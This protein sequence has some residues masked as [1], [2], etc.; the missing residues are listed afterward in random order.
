M[1]APAS[2]KASTYRSG[3]SIIRCTSRVSW[4]ALRSE[5]TTGTPIEMLGTKWPSITSTWS[6][7]APPCSTARISSPR[8]AKFAA[9]MEGAIWTPLYA[10]S[11]DPILT[12]AGCALASNSGSGPASGKRVYQEL[13]ELVRQY[14]RPQRLE[15]LL[16]WEHNRLRVRADYFTSRHP[17]D[18][19]F[20]QSFL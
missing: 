6:I 8:E 5:A 19:D 3:F 13:S 20:F 16:D 7:R 18:T 1:S 9:R 17:G 15:K 10:I 2:A 4:V 11:L 12:R 14:G